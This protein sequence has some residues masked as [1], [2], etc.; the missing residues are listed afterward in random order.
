MDTITQTSRTILFA[1]V[2]PEKLNLLTLIGD[3]RGETSLDDDKIKEINEELVIESLKQFFEKF[4][5]I[6]SKIPIEQILDLSIIAKVDNHAETYFRGIVTDAMIYNSP[7]LE[8]EKNSE[9][10]SKYTSDLS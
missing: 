6:D 7:R 9:L 3:V 5:P 4:A 2:N 10:L 1:E 8:K